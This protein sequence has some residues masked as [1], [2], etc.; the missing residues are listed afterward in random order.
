MAT[1]IIRILKGFSNGHL[2]LSDRG[3][4]RAKRS[5]TIIWQVDPHSEVRRIIRIEKKKGFENIFEP[6]HPSEHGNDWKGDIKSNV[7]IGSE[8]RYS[9][10][11]ENNN[12]N[13]LEFDPIISI[14]PSTV[15]GP[16][17]SLL[18]AI[19]VALLGIFTIKYL[20]QKKILNSF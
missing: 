6:G 19:A 12:G 9:I 16:I 5:E 8:Y 7:A 3:H 14:R 4:T 20:Q 1:R 15:S 10:F 17:A 11:W 13:E 18:I 2:E